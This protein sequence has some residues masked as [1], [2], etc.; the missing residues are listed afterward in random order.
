MKGTF[1][2][3]PPRFVTNVSISFD[4]RQTDYCCLEESNVD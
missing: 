4:N 3:F 1:I 2:S